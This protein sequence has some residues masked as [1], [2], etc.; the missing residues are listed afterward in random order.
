MNIIGAIIFWSAGIAFAFF[1]PRIF[2]RKRIDYSQY[3][4]TTG[5]IM[6]TEKLK[7]DRWIVAFDLDGKE[8]LGMDDCF[9]ASTFKPEK[10]HLPKYGT[11]EKIYYWK[12]TGNSSY[13]INRK[14]VEYYIHFCDE[15]FYTLYDEKERN[16]NIGYR[17]LG[18][19]I[20]FLGMLIFLF[21]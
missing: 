7:G 11:Q 15:S 13:N 21:G 19:I 17:I 8:V 18:A 16:S 12:Y 14:K 5:N 9:A 6:H 4:V 1:I 10:Y 20:I 3:P 2:K